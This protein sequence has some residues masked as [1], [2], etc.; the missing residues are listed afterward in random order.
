MTIRW[1]AVEQFFA[2]VL[3]VFLFYPV[4]NLGNCINFS[5]A[6]V[7]SERVN[8]VINYISLYSA[9]LGLQ[10]INLVFK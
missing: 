5:L 8:S 2:V 9:F 7:R 1:R 10:R 6:T 3:F 4:C